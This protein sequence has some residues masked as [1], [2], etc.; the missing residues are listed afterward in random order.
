MPNIYLRVSS[1]VAAFLRATGDGQ[2]NPPSTPI[3]F[4][5]YTQEH[6]VLVNGLR[7][8]PEGQQH[9]ASCYS[10]SAWQNMSRGI[11]PQGGKAVIRRNPDDY[12]SYAEVCALECMPN[13]TKKF[14]YEFICLAIPREICKNGKIVHTNK[15]FTLD[16]SAAY[17]L[18]SL[19]RN[20]Y[21]RTYVD[22]ENRSKIFAEAHGI[23]RSSVEILERFLMEYDIPVSHTKNEV[24]T[25]RRLAQRWRKE[26]ALMAK[27]PAIITDGMITRIDEHELRGGI[28]SYD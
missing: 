24:D 21:I 1:Y 11:P 3:T 14:G 15:S 22:F 8:V 23:K 12:L 5:P 19:L 18:R 26:A 17:Q 16:S 20:Q 7:I 9:Y 27:A 28:P 10:S 2:S 6:V 13:K 25:L 4:S